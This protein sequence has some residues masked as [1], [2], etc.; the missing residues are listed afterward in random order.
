MTAYADQDYVRADQQDADRVTASPLTLQREYHDGAAVAWQMTERSAENGRPADSI[1][2]CH[3]ELS[4]PTRDEAERTPA[5]AA[6]WSGYQSGADGSVSL[7]RELERDDY[8]RE[9]G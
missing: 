6:W 8:E 7:L 3:D 9:A 2:Q 5:E 4:G 1:E